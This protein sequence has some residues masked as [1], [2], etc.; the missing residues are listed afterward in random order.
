MHAKTVQW[1]FF[2]F[3]TASQQLIESCYYIA[4]KT[5]YTSAMQHLTVDTALYV[6][7]PWE[8]ISNVPVFN[9]GFRYTALLVLLPT[10]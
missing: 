9:D 6:A 8:S 3:T 10:A 5:H 2:I 4:P 7:M 1:L